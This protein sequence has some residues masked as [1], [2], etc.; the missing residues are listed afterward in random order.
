MRAA[1]LYCNGGEYMF[2][3]MFSEM[4]DRC[5]TVRLFYLMEIIL[6]D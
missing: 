4:C 3:D 6:R 5:M 2:N 1:Q